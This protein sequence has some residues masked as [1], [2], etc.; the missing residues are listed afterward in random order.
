MNREP[1]RINQ[2]K[3]QFSQT[4]NRRFHLFPIFACF[5]KLNLQHKLW[6]ISECFDYLIIIKQ[7]TSST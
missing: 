1:G 3:L 7:M 5:L 2:F 4:I 6:I